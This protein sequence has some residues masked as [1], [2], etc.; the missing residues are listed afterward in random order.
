MLTI[1]I[2]AFL[3]ILNIFPY[4]ETS[5]AVLELDSSTFNKTVQAFTFSLVM[6]IAESQK[7]T[8]KYKQ[9]ESV[10]EGLAS[11]KSIL[12]AFTTI[13]GYGSPKNHDLA[14][15][16]QLDQG[17]LPELILLS[18]SALPGKEAVFQETRY[19]SDFNLDQLRKFVQA[20][21]GAWIVLAGCLHEFDELANS[22]V[23]NSKS[24]KDRYKIMA[25]TKRLIDSYD[26]ES[27]VQTG[28]MYLKIMNR[29]HENDNDFILS[30][31]S[32]IETLINQSIS[33]Q[34]KEDFQSKLNILKSFEVRRHSRKDEL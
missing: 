19:G 30:E 26:D 33:E 18:K 29:M 34:K 11:E 9:F 14:L 31:K 20:K 8:F 5:S 6:F 17:K 3:Y 4:G 22:F 32:R 10:A 7:E 13:P 1:N 27:K 23:S 24:G 21:T 12:T 28:K 16:F 25:E 2:F 15:R